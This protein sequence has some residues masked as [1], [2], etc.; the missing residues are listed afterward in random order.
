MFMDD[1][2]QFLEQQVLT[3]GQLLI[4]RDFNYHVD[5]PCNSEAQQFIV[6]L[7]SVNLQPHFSEPIHKHGYTIDLVLGTTPNCIT[8]FP[9]NAYTV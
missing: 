8:V 6:F 1:F 5:D 9:P 7:A 3:S 4:V 2:A